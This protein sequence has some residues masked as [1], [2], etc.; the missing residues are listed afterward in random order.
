MTTNEIMKLADAFSY[1]AASANVGIHI[2]GKTSLL[3]KDKLEKEDE[4]R[5]ALRK[6]VEEMA[7]DAELWRA[8]KA[9]KDAA[10][11]AGLGRNPLRSEETP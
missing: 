10:L 3:V 11:A 6:A 4:A 1:A 5:A 2:F 8:Y 7:A 9:R